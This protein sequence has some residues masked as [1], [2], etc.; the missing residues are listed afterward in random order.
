M[1][2]TTT[3]SLT[4]A[5]NAVDQFLTELRSTPRHEISRRAN[6]IESVRS[7]SQRLHRQLNAKIRK[8]TDAVL[9][10]QAENLLDAA[11]SAIVR[12]EESIA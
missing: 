11:T 9:I 7:T 3:K 2:L 8:G 5:Y 1:T 4:A 10:D 12:Y 6:V